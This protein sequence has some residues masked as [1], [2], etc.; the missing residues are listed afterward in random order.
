MAIEVYSV[1]TDFS[2]GPIDVS[3]FRKEVLADA[4][5]TPSATLNWIQ[6]GVGGDADVVNIDFTPALTNPTQ[7]TALDAVVAAH[8]S[9][10]PLQGDGRQVFEAVVPPTA[11]ED[12]D[13]EIDVGDL[14]VDTNGS[15]VYSC[16]DNTAGAAV[17]TLLAPEAGAVTVSATDPTVTDDAAAGFS[18]GDMWVNSTTGDAFMIVDNTNG[19]AVWRFVTPTIMGGMIFNVEDA[20][21]TTHNNTAFVEKL[22]ATTPTLIA[23]DYIL[24]WSYAWNADTTRRNFEARIQ[25]DNTTDLMVHVQE[26]KDATGNFMSTGSDQRHRA[27]GQIPLT[28]GAAT[29]Q[30]DI[31]FKAP[32]SRT[33]VS[34][35]DARMFL[36]RIA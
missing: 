21:V 33:D 23:G 30:F 35:W 17:W 10:T 8:P 19:A 6:V 15:K 25:Q 5:I 31:D 18:V 29:V 16:V 14:W 3:L 28:L 4:T 20:T 1:A 24:Y 13:D 12:I 7:T 22:T 34:M 27:S 32:N 9:V 26:P 36:V 2:G 11:N